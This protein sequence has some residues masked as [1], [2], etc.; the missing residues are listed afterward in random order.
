MMASESFAPLF[1]PVAETI[2]LFEPLFPITLAK[3][4]TPATPTTLVA[5]RN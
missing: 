4:I 5:K 2:E 1:A 3:P